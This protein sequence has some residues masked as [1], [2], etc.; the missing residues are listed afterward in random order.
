MVTSLHML[1]PLL[2]YFSRVYGSLHACSQ[3][4]G[5]EASV[6]SAPMFPTRA[7][8][9][10]KKALAATGIHPVKYVLLNILSRPCCHIRLAFLRYALLG[11]EPPGVSAP[12]AGLLPPVPDTKF[13]PP[14]PAGQPPA[15]A[16]LPSLAGATGAAPPGYAAAA[17]VAAGVQVPAGTAGTAL[18]TP[19][20]PKD[21]FS[22]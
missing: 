20:V 15:G 8:Q 9:K 12:D 19:A 6:W 17:A 1:L 18:A 13:A 5:V 21:I 11:I 7:V 10:H 3:P 22:R 14:L 4:A 2:E 16:F